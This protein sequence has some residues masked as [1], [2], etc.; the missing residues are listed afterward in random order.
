MR[1]AARNFCDEALAGKCYSAG[2]AATDN[3]ANAVVIHDAVRKLHFMSARVG[4]FLFSLALF[5]SSSM[6]AAEAALAIRGEVK[7]PLSLS[8]SEI[9]SIPVT[10]VRAKDHNG[11]T[12]TYEGVSL[13]ELLQRAG[14][15]QG[16][17][18]RG[19]ALRLCVIA[20]ATDGYQALFALAELDPAVTDKLVLVAFGRDGAEL[21]AATGPLR[22]IV[23]DEKRQARWVRQ[24]TEL[25]VVRVGTARTT[26]RPTVK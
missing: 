17:A 11:T 13:A 19:D 18:L 6:A 2:A 21:D 9:K 26:S 3:D 10:K 5:T 24:V 12:V 23:P 20:K 8:L 4:L 14:V 25:E 16:G 15:P 7:I 1:S 22:I